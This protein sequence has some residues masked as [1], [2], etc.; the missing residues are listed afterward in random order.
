MQVIRVAGAVA[1]AVALMSALLPSR[2]DACSKG[3][4]SP[5]RSPGEIAFMGVASA[6]TVF[7]GAGDVVWAPGR[8]PERAVYG[9]IVSAEQLTQHARRALPP[10]T[11][12]FVVV[13]WDYRMDCEPVQ[14]FGTAAW[15]PAGTRGIFVAKLRDR[16]DWAND[17]PTL[18]VHRPD[19]TPYAYGAGYLSRA[20]DMATALTADELLPLL[21]I[22]PEYRKLHDSVSV[23]AEP[24]LAW[25][26]TNRETAA[27]FP[28][29]GAV[30][31]ARRA[32]ESSWLKRVESPALGTYRFSISMPGMAD[33]MFYG[34]SYDA[35]VSEW[36]R[37]GRPRPAGAD[38]TVPRAP[39]GYNLLMSVAPTL[40]QLETD[41]AKDRRIQGEAY[42]ALVNE[43]GASTAA[44]TQWRGMLELALAA[45]A[46]PDDATLLRLL[47]ARYG[48]PIAPGGDPATLA[49]FTRSADGAMRVE[50]VFQFGDSLRMEIRGERISN[51]VVVGCR[52]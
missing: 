22:M 24:L 23:Y 18:D 17:L 26:R 36:G 28:V 3:P 30:E 47:R 34:R 12:R 52:R 32:V 4:F 8:Q 50:Q 14:K 25:A 37:L 43:T 19:V 42:M 35:P 7:A 21:D 49:R 1:S 44:G 45:R 16:K 40:E 31:L 11:T 10:N 29:A 13:P 48:E 38:P 5:L 20:R 46:F 27:R 6:D 9:L 39:F 41:C 2:A 51:A 33:R 15:I